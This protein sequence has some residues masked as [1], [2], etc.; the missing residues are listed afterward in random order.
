MNKLNI[1]KAKALR[2][3]IIKNL[4]ELYDMPIPLSKIEDLLRY[5]SFYSR[6][7][8]GKAVAYLS[9]IKKE[10]VTVR[11][12]EKDYWASFIKLTPTG[13]NLAEGDITDMGVQF[14]E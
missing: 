4:Y 1:A 3:D 6:D 13:I 7:D 8:I 5:K 11:I 12:N 14:S 2:G 9:G 10:F